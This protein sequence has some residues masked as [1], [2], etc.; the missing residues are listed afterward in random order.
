VVETLAAN[1]T[2]EALADGVRFRCPD[3]GA[4]HPGAHA[5]GDS[6]EEL[7]ELRVTVA[8]QEARPLA[9]RRSVAQLLRDPCVAGRACDAGLDHPSGSVLDE[10]EREDGPEQRV[11][12]LQLLEDD[13][14]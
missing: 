4:N 3:R 13:N 12:E 11:V 8:K 1:A 7:A 5:S 9:V 2:E 6:L 10:E 14:E